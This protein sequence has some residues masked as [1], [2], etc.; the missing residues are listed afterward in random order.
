MARA[1]C[2]SIFFGVES[3]SPRIQKIIDKRLDLAEARAHVTLTTRH[4]MR[5]TVSTIVGFPEETID[6]VKATV[7]FLAES[8]RE[9]ELVTQFH[10]LAPLAGTPL[11]VQY[12]DQL[13]LEDL[14]TDM[15]HSGWVQADRSAS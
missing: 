10:L 13:V 1:G 4:G 15:S 11:E 9:P 12:R 6:D 14:Y 7:G 2:V 8:L 5:T 3:G